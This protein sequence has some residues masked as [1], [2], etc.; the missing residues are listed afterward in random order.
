MR[1]RVIAVGKVTDPEIE[2]YVKRSRSFMPIERVATRDNGGAIEQGRKL[3]ADALKQ[4]ERQ[5]GELKTLQATLDALPADLPLLA[6]DELRRQRDELQAQVDA[7]IYALRYQ[8]ELH[9]A[10][11]GPS[12]QE[13]TTMQHALDAFGRR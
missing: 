1:L 3:A 9:P 6:P 10:G 11:D 4:A 5:S 8:G 13:W 7:A 12:A 2:E